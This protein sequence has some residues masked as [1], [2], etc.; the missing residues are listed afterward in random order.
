[1]NVPDY[2]NDHIAK[3]KQL[4]AIAPQAGFDDKCKFL[5]EMQW[6]VCTVSKRE[7]DNPESIQIEK[8]VDSFIDAQ[9]H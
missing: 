6:D 2:I 7:K 4:A 9:V 3:L 5:E 1:M 8:Y